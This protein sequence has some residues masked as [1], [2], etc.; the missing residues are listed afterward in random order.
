M[1]INKNLLQ[2]GEET[3]TNQPVQIAPGDRWQVY[4]RLQDLHVPCS[5]NL[6]EPLLIELRSPLVIL[7]VWQVMRQFQGKRTELIDWLE[8]CWAS[9]LMEVSK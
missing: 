1:E 8:T 7:Q 5:C 6:S 3:M 4:Y 9:N 2:L